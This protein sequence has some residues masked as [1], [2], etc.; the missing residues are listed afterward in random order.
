MIWDIWWQ[1]WTYKVS[2]VPVLLTYLLL[3]S[4]AI[5]RRITKQY[6]VPIYFIIFPDGHTDKMY[7]EYF[8]EDD[9]Y[10]V[11]Q[12]MSGGGEGRASPEDLDLCDRIDAVR[13]C[14]CS[15]FMRH[16]FG[17]LSFA[18]AVQRVCLVSSD[19]KDIP[20]RVC[21]LSA[22]YRKSGSLAWR[23]LLLR[24]RDLHCLC[25]FCVA[26]LREVVCLGISRVND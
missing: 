1:V 12:E 24:R 23:R 3:D 6:Y 18:P 26:G 10:G 13:D 17:L 15:I 9:F 5:I 4:Q 14:S 21:T 20:D 8:S 16:R 11:G 7:A 25:L 22:A 2:L 19:C